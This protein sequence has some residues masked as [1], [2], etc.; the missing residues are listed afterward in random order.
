MPVGINTIHK[1]VVCNLTRQMEI[2]SLEGVNNTD[3]LN[4]FNESFSDYFIPFK[5]TKEQLIS[6]MISDKIDLELSV[7]VFENKKL[8][9]FILHG[10]DTINSQKIVYNGGTGVIPKKRGLGLTKR[11]YQ[12]ALPVLVKRGT[13]KIILEVI[14]KNIQAIKSYEKSGFKATRELA[15]FKGYFKPNKSNN[16]TEIKELLDYQWSLMES[17]WD[18]NT[19]WQNSKNVMSKLI[20]EN[21][22]FGAYAK[23][24]LIGYVIYSPKSKRIQQ[25]AIH[26]DFRKK[27]IATKLITELARKYG[28][29]FSIINVDKKAKNVT[30]FF[31]SIGFENYIEQLELELKLT[32]TTA[33]KS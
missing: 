9:A 10:L 4:V 8:I 3:I 17:F 24:Q 19:T 14:T 23:N 29:Y 25:L 30:S 22:S 28:N 27:G 12:F 31:S 15:C 5:L 33:N 32:K 21:T 26:K 1:S 13:D 16:D 20:A 11:M 18:I 7:G 2:K 6:K